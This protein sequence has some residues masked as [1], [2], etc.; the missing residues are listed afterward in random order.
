M[1]ESPDLTD[2]AISTAINTAAERTRAMSL[3]YVADGGQP[4]ISARGSIHVH[5]PQQLA[6]W[7]RSRQNGLIAS[8]PVRPKVAA[9]YVAARDMPPPWYLA[10]DGTAR[11]DE[12]SNDAVYARIS[13]FERDHDPE[14]TGVAVIIDV[15]RMLCYGINGLYE[16]VR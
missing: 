1:H 3:A 4:Q 7:S 5:G 13:Q 15:H 16:V 11:I 9:L 6:M 8:L 14:R 2:E 10:L 12:A